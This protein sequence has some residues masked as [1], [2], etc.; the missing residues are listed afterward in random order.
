MNRLI[1]VDYPDGTYTTTE[2][3]ND[4]RKTA[5]VDQVLKRTEYSND[6][7][8]RLT[9]AR[10]I[11]SGGNDAPNSMYQQAWRRLSNTRLTSFNVFLRPR[12]K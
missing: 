6:G 4:G 2:Y 1:R 7:Q 8:G 11:T 12:I 3:D 10:Q 5:S 9:E